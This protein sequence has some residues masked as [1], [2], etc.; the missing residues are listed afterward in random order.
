MGNT[1]V[2][3]SAY[4]NKPSTKNV[5]SNAPSAIGLNLEPVGRM[6][7]NDVPAPTFTPTK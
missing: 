4:S 2:Q 6:A 5:F 1:S 7:N 3:G